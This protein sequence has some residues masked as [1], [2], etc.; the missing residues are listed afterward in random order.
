MYDH[1]KVIDHEKFADTFE[2]LERLIFQRKEE[3]KFFELR[4]KLSQAVGASFNREYVK[5]LD[6]EIWLLIKDLSDLI[7]KT[8]PGQIVELEKFAIRASRMVDF[9]KHVG[10]KHAAAMMVIWEIV[11]VAK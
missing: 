1:S 6:D 9:C 2:D 4:E 8:D 3:Q 5:N 11:A 10:E 7:L